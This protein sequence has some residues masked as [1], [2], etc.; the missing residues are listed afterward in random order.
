LKGTAFFLARFA[1][2]VSDTL[3]TGRLVVSDLNLY[4]EEYKMLKDEAKLYTDVNFRELQFSLTVVAAFV[5][6]GHALGDG[7]VRIWAFAVLQ[8]VLYLFLLVQAS[9]LAYLL[10]LRRHLSDLEIELNTGQKTKLQWESE[11]VPKKLA[12]LS[13]LNYKTQLLISSAYVMS[14]LM[15]ALY[16]IKEVWQAKLWWLYLALIVVEF[17]TLGYFA[18]Q[19]VRKRALVPHR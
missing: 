3:N 13:S 8:F 5:A 9:R 4:F 16:S 7:T 19:I 12:T 1:T 10:S 11:I 6:V 14:F 2:T 15:L 18:D 17:L